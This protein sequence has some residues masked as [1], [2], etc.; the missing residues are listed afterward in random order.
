MN[1]N[2]KN[3][4][5]K[6]IMEKMNHYENNM[7]NRIQANKGMFSGSIFSEEKVRDILNSIKGVFYQI[8]SKTYVDSRERTLITDNLTRFYIDEESDVGKVLIHI[9]G[10]FI[11]DILLDLAVEIESDIN[12]ITGYEDDKPVVLTNSNYYKNNIKDN[13]EFID[14][15][16]GVVFSIVD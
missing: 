1:L 11:H 14:K 7:N 8:I 15:F 4:M 3:Y 10:M 16:Q 9:M 5:G 12:F 2:T 6:K 13:Q